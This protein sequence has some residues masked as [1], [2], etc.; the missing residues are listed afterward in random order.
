MAVSVVAIPFQPKVSLFTMFWARAA[1]KHRYLQAFGRPVRLNTMLYARVMK[2]E[3][4]SPHVHGYGVRTSHF[5]FGMG[6]DGILPDPELIEASMWF[7]RR[8]S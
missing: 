5:F 4:K 1:P 6:N 8:L 7:L 2:T 3:P